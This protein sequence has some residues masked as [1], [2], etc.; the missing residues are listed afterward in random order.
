MSDDRPSRRRIAGESAPATGRSAAQGPRVVRKPVRRPG[1]PSTRS[2]PLDPK[3]QHAAEATDVDSESTTEVPSVDSSAA[4]ADHAVAHDDAS[5][6][7]KP[8]RIVPARGLLRRRGRSAAEDASSD[9]VAAGSTTAENART[10]TGRARR[11]A[12]VLLAV[13][14]VAFAAAAGYW[15]YGQ[16]RGATGIAAAHAEA[17]TAATDAAQEILSYR[18]D[19]LDEHLEKSQALMTPDFAEEFETISPA[20]NDLA[21]QR[22]IVVEATAREAAPTPCGDDCSTDEAEILVFVDQARVA[23]GEQQPTVFGNRITMSMVRDG[24]TWL[25]DDIEAY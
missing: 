15:A 22:Q 21:P 10:G 17:E 11:V 14:A 1:A 24:G 3:T 18:Y 23:D 9:R 4:A 6:A 25:V 8:P 19:Q 7:E 20:L 13:L 12:V 16:V 2:E 5:D